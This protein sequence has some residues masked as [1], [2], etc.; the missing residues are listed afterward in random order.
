MCSGC[1]CNEEHIEQ[2]PWLQCECTSKVQVWPGPVTCHQP[3]CGPFQLS[4]LRGLVTELHPNLS[5][6]K[7]L[8]PSPSYLPSYFVA[9]TLCSRLLHSFQSC[10]QTSTFSTIFR[11]LLLV[12]KSYVPADDN[13]PVSWCLESIFTLSW[14]VQAA[15]RRK[16]VQKR[17]FTLVRALKDRFGSCM[18]ISK[19]RKPQKQTETVKR[20]NKEDADVIWY[21]QVL[22]CCI[23]SHRN[24]TVER[25]SLYR[26]SLRIQPCNFS[27]L[28]I[29]SFLS[30][31]F[32]FISLLQALLH[33]PDTSMK[34]FMNIT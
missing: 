4:L 13:L 32:T 11:V 24:S 6:L 14:I 18:E 16:H 27:F 34:S 31:S 7:N 30:H 3:V 5:A 28:R 9:P 25:R 15:I 26:F 2:V 12:K 17:G 33:L 1:S 10:W 8:L 20:N 22:F 23:T 29:S 19:Q 21:F